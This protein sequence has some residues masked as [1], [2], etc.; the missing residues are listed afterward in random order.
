I[1]RFTSGLYQARY[2][3]ALALAGLTLLNGEDI[4][5]AVEDYGSAKAMCST[6]GVLDMNLRLVDSLDT[7]D[8]L[9]PVRELL[10]E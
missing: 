10:R 6:A 9:D 2:A 3:H 4:V 5:R 7:G 1:L 8:T